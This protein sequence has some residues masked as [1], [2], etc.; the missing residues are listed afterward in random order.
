M[1]DFYSGLQSTAL[2][3]LAG[4][5]DS[6]TLSVLTGSVYD[7]L[8]QTNVPSYVDYPVSVFVGNYAGRVNEGGTLVQTNDRKL[9]VSGAGVALDPQTSARIT[10]GGVT[11]TIENIQPVG[12]QG[13]NVIFVMQGRS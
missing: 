1:S 5:G 8:A 11:Y 7:P 6:G 2:A 3:L 13:V 9:I 4:K 12:G 10:A